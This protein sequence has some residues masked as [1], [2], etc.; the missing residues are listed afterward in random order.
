MKAVDC[1]TP[2]DFA[3]VEASWGEPVSGTYRGTEIL[4]HAPNGQGAAAILLARILSHFDVAALDPFGADRAH[5]DLEATKLAYD[6]RDRFLADLDHVTRLAHMLDP[7]TAER[8]SALIDMKKAIPDAAPVSEAVHRD[9]VY[10][11]VVDAERMAVSLIYS[12]FHSFGS[13][14]ASPKFGILLQN[15]G[16]GFS[17]EQGH[18]NEATGGKRP[19]HT[20]IPGMLAREG[21]VVMPFGVMGGQYQAAGHARFVSN[22]VDFDMDPQEAIDGPRCF[23]QDGIATVE[24]GYSDAVRA[25]LAERGHVVEVPQAPIGGAQAILIDEHAGTLTAGSDPRKDGCAIGY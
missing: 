1:N 19:M 7:A 17:L 2:D 4:E 10:I 14:I 21:R 11:T 3:E 8:L 5:L 23:T 15:R 18:P 9:T 22:V 12:I 20:I 13:G 24:R 6:A 25:E 16:Q